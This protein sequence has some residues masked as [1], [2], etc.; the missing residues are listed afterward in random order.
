VPVRAYDKS[1]HAGAMNRIYTGPEY[2]SYL[3]LP[4]VP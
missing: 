1:Y 3:Q 2:P 4:I